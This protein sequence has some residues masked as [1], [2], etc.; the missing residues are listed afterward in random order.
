VGGDFEAS[1]VLVDGLW[2]SALA[3]LAP[4]GF[5]VAVPCRDILAFCDAENASGLQELR[6]II[7]RTQDGEHPIS[8]LL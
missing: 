7:G 3:H 8:S 5:V 4:N 1:A 2:N 6:Q